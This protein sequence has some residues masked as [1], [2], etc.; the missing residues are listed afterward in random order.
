MEPRSR[1]TDFFNR[2]GRLLPFAD[3]TLDRPLCDIAI[4]GPEVECRHAVGDCVAG[5]ERE[6]RQA[7]VSAANVREHIDSVTPR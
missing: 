1:G 2:I 6:D 3:Y 7:D 5:G 4:V